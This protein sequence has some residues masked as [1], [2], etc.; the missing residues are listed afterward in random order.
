VADAFG[1]LGFGVSDFGV[2][3]GCSFTV[4]LRVSDHL[5]S[6]HMRTGWSGHWHCYTV[7]DG[8]IMER[9]DERSPDA[10]IESSY[11]R[12]ARF[13]AGFLPI[14]SAIGP[15]GMIGGEFAVL[16]AFAGLLA[17]R[18]GSESARRLWIHNA[19]EQEAIQHERVHAGELR[20]TPTE[21]V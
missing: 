5:E 18:S 14:G 6:E 8:Q 2:L 15:Y 20:P 21:D 19:T 11:W 9:S 7:T 1:V 3:V 17:T 13:G 4:D 10:W 16:G 12:L